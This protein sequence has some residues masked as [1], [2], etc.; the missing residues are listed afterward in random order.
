MNRISVHLTQEEAT[1][2]TRKL[3]PRT[4]AYQGAVLLFKRL[5]RLQ[6]YYR[7]GRR[8]RRRSIRRTAVVL[9]TAG[10][11]ATGR[12]S[13]SS[14]IPSAS[15]RN[16][17]TYQPQ[18]DPSKAVIKRPKSMFQYYLPSLAGSRRIGCWGQL[19]G[20]PSRR[21]HSHIGPLFHDCE[22]KPM[23]QCLNGQDRDLP[24]HDIKARIALRVDSWVI[25]HAQ[26]AAAHLGGVNVD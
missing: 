1:K 6:W 26:I 24:V 22:G 8:R 11:V 4:A 15:I 13:R 2:L 3:T 14:L 17:P 21:R 20:L 19:R 5:S 16:I 9:R 10:S 23:V 25:E 7:C 18:H 12:R